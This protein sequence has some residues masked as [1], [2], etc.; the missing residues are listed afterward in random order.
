MRAKRATFTFWVDKSWLKNAQ[1]GPFWRLFEDLKLAV[2]QTY[3]TN[4]FWK[5]KNRWK[6][7]KFQNSNAS[8]CVIFKHRALR[9]IKKSRFAQKYGRLRRRRR[10][11]FLSK[12]RKRKMLPWRSVGVVHNTAQMCHYF[13]FSFF[14][15]EYIT[16]S[17]HF[18]L[19]TFYIFLHV[20]TNYNKVFQGEKVIRMYFY[21]EGH[22]GKRPKIILFY[23]IFVLLMGIEVHT[24]QSWKKGAWQFS[25]VSFAKIQQSVWKI[26]QNVSDGAVTYFLIK[27]SAIFYHDDELISDVF[28][29][30]LFNVHGVPLQSSIIFK[31]IFHKRAEL[32]GRLLLSNK[33]RKRAARRTFYPKSSFN[34]N[35]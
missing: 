34:L 19:L 9:I 14:T 5:E 7:P 35:L 4:Q 3:Q 12:M 1:N 31:C 30:C 18:L 15:N 20:I 2:K 32:L 6:I 10:V 28:S 21:V 13:S 16:L 22:R 27:F 25:H 33:K 8:F 11:S 29:W 23:V 17:I 24:V 26:T